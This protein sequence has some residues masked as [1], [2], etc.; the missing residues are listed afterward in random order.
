MPIFTRTQA[1]AMPQKV[2]M[3]GVWEQIEA[4]ARTCYRSEGKTKYDENGDSLTAEAFANKIVRVYKHASVAEHAAIY[5]V[6]EPKDTASADMIERYKRNKYSKVRDEEIGSTIYTFISTNLRVLIDNEWEDDLRLMVE[7]TEHHIRRRTVRLFTDRGVSA[8]SNRHRIQSP[9]ERS[10]R[11]VN[12]GHDGAIT[13][14]VPQELEDTDIIRSVEEFGGAELCFKNMCSS[15]GRGLEDFGEIDAW[16][17]AQYATEWSYLRLLKLGWKPQQA[18]R[19]LPLDT[20]TELVIS[21]YD[22]E[23]ARYFQMRYYGT[24]G[25]PHPDMKEA[26]GHIMDQFVEMNWTE[27]LELATDGLP[28]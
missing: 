1:I 15:I 14:C 23:W 27:A 21:A 5:F 12:Y 18:R 7:P 3:K 13:I 10:T 22:D 9:T 11:F 25:S 8:E 19:V 6:V 16:L 26:C 2:G 20:E 28:E 4:A 17:F 24:T